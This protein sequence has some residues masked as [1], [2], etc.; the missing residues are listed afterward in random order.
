M[1]YSITVE[2]VM[3]YLIC[4]QTFLKSRELNCLLAYKCLHG[5]LNEEF[6][7]L[8]KYWDE[9]NHPIVFNQTMHTLKIDAY[10]KP[11]I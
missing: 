8:I 10:I 1:K 9:T 11:S 5:R 2:Q 6:L 7:W 4:L 3:G